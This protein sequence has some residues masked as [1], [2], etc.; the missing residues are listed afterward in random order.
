[1]SRRNSPVSGGNIPLRLSFAHP[2]GIGS[3]EL[4]A[5]DQNISGIQ[6]LDG[7]DLNAT[8]EFFEE[9]IEN[10]QRYVLRLEVRDDQARVFL[11]GEIRQT[12]DLTDRTLGV[13]DPMGMARCSR[14]ECQYGNRQFQKSDSISPRAAAKTRI[15]FGRRDLLYLPKRDR[16]MRI[17][18]GEKTPQQLLRS[19]NADPAVCQDLVPV[20][21]GVTRKSRTVVVRSGCFHDVCR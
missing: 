21:L 3:V 9:V 8:G 15:R 14:V 17:I 11:N 16:Y 13:S 7:L 18:G 2:A 19:R 1:M 10:G 5:W 6:L 4:D 12:V 20:R